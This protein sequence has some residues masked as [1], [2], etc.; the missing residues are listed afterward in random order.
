MDITIRE[1]IIFGEKKV[2][3]RYLNKVIS[4]ADSEKVVS[5]KP[6]G[7]DSFVGDGEI[8]LSGGQR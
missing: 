2:D 5:D 3:N 7:L 6:G 8:A 4:L 1:N